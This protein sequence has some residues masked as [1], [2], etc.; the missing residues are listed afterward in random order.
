VKCR[1]HS[2]DSDSPG[3]LFCPHSYDTRT[4]VT[5]QI[6]GRVGGWEFVA[7]EEDEGVSEG[8]NIV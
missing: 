4:D 1:L 5:I 7:T 3:Q 8:G 6:A 2:D